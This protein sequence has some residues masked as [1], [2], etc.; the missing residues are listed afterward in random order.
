MRMFCLV[1]LIA[2]FSVRGGYGVEEQRQELSFRNEV[3]LAISRGLA[4]LKAQ[5]KP[6]GYWSLDEHPALTALPLMAFRNEPQGRYREGREEF[7]QRGYQFI[8]SKAQP[9]GG[10]YVRGLSNYNTSLALLAL[11]HTG[12]AEDDLLVRKARAFLIGQQAK[13]MADES[14]DGGVGYGPTGVSPKR[15]HPD[16][17]NTL[18]ALEAL[19]AFQAAHASEEKP[20]Q[21]DL[22][23]K[24]AIEF[25]SRTQ[26]L[27]ETNPKAS[28]AEEDR[29]GFVYYPGFSNA[30]PIQGP[31]ALR[32]YGSMS[33]AGLLSFIYADLSKEDPR[34]L[35]AVEWLSRNYSVEENPGMGKAGLYYYYY[36]MTKGLTAAGIQ[37]LPL[38]DGKKVAWRPLLARKVLDLQQGDGSW[39]NENGRWMEKDPVLVTSYCVL[40]LEMLVNRP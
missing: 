10:I 40:L 8:R 3:Q 11:L 24:A 6:E 5:Q 35:A 15:Q 17:D 36:L 30:D 34:V 2:F 12:V 38:A 25:I 39:A 21:D 27:P 13:G 14:L 4:Y 19:R 29:G 20:S 28:G 16:L 7:I 22:N 9:D 1:F 32:S 18:V 26:N 23:W 33:Y 31:R 37:Q